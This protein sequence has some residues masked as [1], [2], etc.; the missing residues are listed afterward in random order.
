MSN[1]VVIP[2]V[3]EE[4]TVFKTVRRPKLDLSFYSKQMRCWVKIENILADTGADISVLPKSLG[5]LLIGDFKN[6]LRYKVSGLTPDSI[7]HMYIHKLSVKLG[8]KKFRTDFAISNSDNVPPTLGRR[9]AL[10][11]FEVVYQ[12]GKNLV[13]NWD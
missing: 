10:D 3:D 11:K 7:D 6:G 8:N 12:K 1:S 9:G 5:L 2:Y 13:I 4:S